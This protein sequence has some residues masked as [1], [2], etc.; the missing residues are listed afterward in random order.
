M[1][2][3]K[4]ILIAIIT[5]LF[6]VLT[7]INL[8]LASPESNGDNTIDMLEIMTRAFDEGGEGPGTKACVVVIWFPSDSAPNTK[9][10]LCYYMFD[11]FGQPVGPPCGLMY[12]CYYKHNGGGCQQSICREGNEP[13]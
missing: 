8:S 6:A 7:V 4:P 11:E 9:V 2:N 13:S 1:K 10:D 3:K 5:S 12:T